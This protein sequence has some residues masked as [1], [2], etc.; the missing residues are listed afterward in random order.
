MAE[1]ID[2]QFAAPK[3]DVNRPSYMLI[4]GLFTKDQLNCV[5]ETIQN[6]IQ[7]GTLEYDCNSIQSFSKLNNM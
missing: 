3:L 4:I 5:K 1:A 2:N 6:N 7:N